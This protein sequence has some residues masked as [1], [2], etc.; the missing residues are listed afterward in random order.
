MKGILTVIGGD[1]MI[2]FLGQIAF[3]QGDQS[4]F[5]IHNHDCF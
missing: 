2:A 3:D 4:F 5:I 1:Y